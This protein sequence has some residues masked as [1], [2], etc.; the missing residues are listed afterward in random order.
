MT[1]WLPV[2]LQTLYADVVDRSWGGSYA[3]LLEAGGTPYKRSVKGRDYWYFKT[4]PVG[5]GSRKDLYLGTDTGAVRQRVD[6]LR[7]L[8]RIRRDRISMIRALRAAGLPAP[9]AM[10][11]KVLSALCEAGV[12]RLQAVIVGTL[13]FQTY[14]PM[15]G[16]RF[17]KRI[18]QASDSAEPQSISIYVDD[19]IEGDLLPH[20]HIV[21]ERFRLAPQAFDRTRSLKYVLGSGTQEEFSVC[22]LRPL[23][24]PERRCRVAERNVIQGDDEILGFLGFLIKGKVN[25]VALHGI[26]VPVN[27]PAPERYAVHKLFEA[28]M[29]TDTDQSQAEARKDL[30]Q[31]QALIEVLLEDRPYELQRVWNEALQ[32]GPMWSEK[33]LQAAG[34]IEVGIKERLLALTE[35]EI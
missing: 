3:E 22:I 11:G 5:T 16:V 25:A 23:A 35:V 15:L 33:L 31:A 28:R 2:S 10:S 4:S 27:V 18:T 9:D 29:R 21:D 6:E 17:N 32:Q 20:L 13:A 1:E 30:A 7:D 12:S 34:M 19:P 8:K 26:G 14:G 24:G